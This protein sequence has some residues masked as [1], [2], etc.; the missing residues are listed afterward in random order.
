VK[1]NG[2]SRNRV[3]IFCLSSSPFFSKDFHF[4]PLF[5]KEGSGEI[6]KKVFVPKIPPRP[7]FPK[8][9]YQRFPLPNEEHVD[10]H[11]FKGFYPLTSMMIQNNKVV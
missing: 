1:N 7:P 6:L 3:G 8:G 10:S 4:P 2:S 9:G 5:G 11:I